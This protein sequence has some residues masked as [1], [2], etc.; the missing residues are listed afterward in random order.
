MSLGIAPAPHLGVVNGSMIT[1]QPRSWYTASFNTTEEADKHSAEDPCLSKGVVSV[2][3]K[4]Q[5]LS[6]ASE[7]SV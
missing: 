2:G 6:G 7:V 1:F 3:E 4:E 5:D